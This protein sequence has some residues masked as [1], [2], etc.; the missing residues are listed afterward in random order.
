MCERT[1]AK[2]EEELCPTKEEKERLHQLLDAVF[3]QHQVVLHRTDV[4][5]PPHIKEE[6]EYPQHPHIKEEEEDPQLSHIKEEEE[7]THPPHIK[8]DGEEVL[9]TQE[10]ECLLGQ[11]EDD[12]TKFPLTVVSVKTEEHEDKP[13]ESSQ[14]HHRP[15]V[16]Q[17]PHIKEEEEYPQPPHIKEEEE[18]PQLSHIKEEEEGTH[19]PHNKDDEEEVWI[20]QE[21]ECLLGQEE[22]DLTKFPLTVVSVKTEEHEDKPP[23]SSQLHHSPNVEQPPHIK[24][25]EEYPQHPHLEEEGTHPPHIKDDEE[26]VWI[27]QE[28]ECLLG[29]EEDDLTKFP[30]T[31]VSV[32]TEEHEDKS[33]ESSQL[34]H[35]PNIPDYAGLHPTCY[36]R[37]IDKKRLDSAEKLAKRLDVGQ[38]ES[39]ASDNASGSTSDIPKK[40]LR[41]ETGLPIGS[42]GPVLPAIC[43]ICKRTDKRVFVRGKRQRDQLSQAKTFSAGQLLNAAR[44]KQDSSLLLHIEDR[45]CVAMEVRYHKSCYRQYTRFLT[46]S[47]VTVTGTA[48]EKVEPTFDASYNI[49]CERIIRQRIIVNQEVLRMNE[50]RRMFLNTVQN[51]EDCDASNYR[52]DQLK[53][54]LILDFPQLVFHCFGKGNICEQVFVETLSADKLIDRLPHPSGT[55]TT[56]STEVSKGESDNSWDANY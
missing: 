21:G 50:L 38:D 36:Q 42:A 15:N 47:D 52:Q 32:K 28:G 41:S 49:F 56:E 5:Q 4:Q 27:T 55:D 18:D 29:Q 23:E 44:I 20:T 39:V 48:G 16:Q 14:L 8:D 46:K 6:E 45:D 10:G 11:E 19:P 35:S 13:P 1:I 40:R 31:V 53:T 24:E 2:Y 34:H 30:L 33:P 17:P 7:G 26:E 12:L 43:I 3:K 9:I 22:D 54:R 51:H 37:F 25:E